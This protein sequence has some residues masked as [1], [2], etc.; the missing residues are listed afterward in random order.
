MLAHNVYFTLNDNSDEACQALI[1]SCYKH[2]FAEP[3]VRFGTV[4]LRT[5]SLC[6]PVN[7]ADFEVALLLLFESLEDHDR[8]QTCE[9]HLAFI[10]ENQANFKAV[11]VFDFDQVKSG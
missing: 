6:R 9:N 10:A 4:G 11:R 2:L 8:Y 1:D 7:D 3:G 5:P